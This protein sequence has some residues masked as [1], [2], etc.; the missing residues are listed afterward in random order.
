M[1]KGPISPLPPLN[2]PAEFLAAARANCAARAREI[3]EAERAASY[4]R[5]DQDL[6]WALRHEVSRLRAEALLSERCEAFEHD[7]EVAG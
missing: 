5:G 1:A 3:G 2:A 4:E 7:Q 6:G